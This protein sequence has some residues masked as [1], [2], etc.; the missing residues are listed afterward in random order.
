M[1]E[2]TMTVFTTAAVVALLQSAVTSAPMAANG[3]ASVSGF[4]IVAAVLTK[5]PVGLFPLAAPM[6]LP[7]LHEHR[8]RWRAAIGQW[9]TLAALFAALW[10]FDASRDGV[11][12]YLH[13]QVFP[14]LDHSYPATIQSFG[15]VKALL[16]GVFLPLAVMAFLIVVGGGFVSPSIACRTNAVRVSFLGLAGTLPILV[17]SKQMGHYLVPAVPFFALATAMILFPTVARLTERLALAGRTRIVHI[18]AGAIVLGT[19]IAAFL[20]ALERETERLVDLAAL[21]SA[22]PRGRT[23]SICAGASGDWGLHAWV[24]RLYSVSL[25]VRSSQQSEW[26]LRTSQDSPDCGPLPCTPVTDSRRALF[27][28]RCRVP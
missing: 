28:M 1:L 17:S 18:A 6:F 12:E 11:T 16:Q 13:Q 23:I 24:E 14:A 26:L 2:T 21:S 10:T 3:W 15:I 5:G 22:V 4:C 9:V 7:D 8:W 20:P 25:D 27:L 19:T